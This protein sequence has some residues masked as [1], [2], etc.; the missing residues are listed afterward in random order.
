[1]LPRVELLDL[2]KLTMGNNAIADETTVGNS[3]T[4]WK[5]HIGLIVYN[6][7]KV[8]TVSTRICPGLHIWDGTLW[9]PLKPY[10]ALETKKTFVEAGTIGKTTLIADYRSGIYNAS[11]TIWAKLGKSP[12]DY[13]NGTTPTPNMTDADGNTYASKRFYVA[14]QE[15]TGD[16]Y[17]TEVNVSCDD[18]IANWVETG[19]IV[20]PSIIDISDG[21]WITS[22]VYST[23]KADGG[24]FDLG[25]YDNDNQPRLNPAYYTIRNNSAAIKIGVNG[26]STT[27]TIQYGQSPSNITS[28]NIT[29]N[30]K[31]F[32]TIFGLLYN[33]NQANQVCPKGW[34]LPNNDEWELLAESNGGDGTLHSDGAAIPMFM[35]HDYYRSYDNNITRQWG[36][37]NEELSGF[38]AVPSGQ[39]QYNGTRA[40]YFSDRTYWWSSTNIYS[41]CSNM[42][43]YSDFNHLS[44][45]GIEEE[46]RSPYYSVRCMQN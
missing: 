26:L 18:N 46:N 3:S 9:Q 10:P 22:N 7:A 2:T 24:A 30:Q 42:I 1:M 27:A 38:N 37:P 31:D 8:E 43:M 36:K 34:H 20:E 19:T 13:F 15:T 35:N 5:D 41:A 23:Q 4:T 44:L 16:V 39:V 14:T 32:A 28:T 6:V 29:I 40:G 25:E 11:D 17:K 12:T 45:S 33:I 21:V